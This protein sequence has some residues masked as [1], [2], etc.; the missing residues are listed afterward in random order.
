MSKKRSKMPRSASSEIIRKALR[1]LQEMPEERHIDLLVKS[2]LITLEQAEQ[3]KKKWAEIQAAKENPV[4]V[5][6]G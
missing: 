1:N 6:A 3:A 4:V 2:K 5:D